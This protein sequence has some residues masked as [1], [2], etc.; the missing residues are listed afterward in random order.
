MWEREAADY[1]LLS[2]SVEMNGILKVDRNER[3]DLLW[4][5]CDASQGG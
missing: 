5:H 4:T 1:A 2:E 3:Y